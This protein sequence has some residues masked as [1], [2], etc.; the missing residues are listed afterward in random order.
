MSS[1]VRLVFLLIISCAVHFVFG[2]IIGPSIKSWYDIH[3]HVHSPA[4]VR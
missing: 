3:V 2:A 1:G 4:R